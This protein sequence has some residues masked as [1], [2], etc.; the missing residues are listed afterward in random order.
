MS[1]RRNQILF[2][3]CLVV[4][5]NDGRTHTCGNKYNGT[6]IRSISVSEAILRSILIR[7]K[8]RPSMTELLHVR[9]C[10]T[11]F[12]EII[13]DRASQFI[14]FPKSTGQFNGVHWNKFDVALC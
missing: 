9:L 10:C 6:H 8:K 3:S 13:A 1:V 2:L 5:S 14:V 11:G 4:F 12:I 7:L